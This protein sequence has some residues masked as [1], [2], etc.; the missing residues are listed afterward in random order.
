MKKRTLSILLA[1]SLLISTI[2]V[3]NISVY[4]D[5]VVSYGAWYESMYAEWNGTSGTEYTVSYKES[6]TDN[7]TA[8]DKELVREVNSGQFRVDVLGL[9][10]NV[11]YD[12]KIENNGTSVLEFTD[13]PMAYDRSGFAFDGSNNAPGAYNADGT[14]AD[15]ALIIYASEA[16]KSKVYNNK[17][18][19]SILGGFNSLNGG[20]PV[21]LRIIGKITPVGSATSPGMWKNTCGVTI[22]GVGPGAGFSGWGI[23]SGDNSDTEFR[24]LNFAD[25]VEDAIGFENAKKLWVH[26]NN[27]YSGYNPKDSTAERDKLHGD[28][29]CDLRECNNV[30]VSYNHFDGTDKTSLIGSSST[31][32]EST[33]NIT[34]HHNFF[35]GTSQRTPRV[36]WHNI[37]AYNNYYYNTKAYGIG[38]TCNCSIFAENNYF[39]DAASP[40]LTSSQGGYASKFS[41]NEGGVIK[42]YNNTFVNT[43]ECVEGVDF[44]NAPS[45]EYRMTASDFTTV[46]GGWTYNNFDSTG[47]IASNSY[48]L[49]SPDEAKAKV[50]AEAGTIKESK[51]QNINTMNPP[52]VDGHVSAVYYYDP[53]TTGST[54]NNYGGLNG[55]GTYFSGAGTCTNNSATGYRGTEQ[56]HY[57]GSFS[58]SATISFTTENPAKFTIICSTSGT[59]PLRMEVKNSQNSDAVYHGTFQSGNKGGDVLTTIDLL[60]AGTYSFKANSNVDIYYMEVAEYNGDTPI[61]ESTT[62][63]STTVI[64]TES[65][66]STTVGTT[67]TTTDATTEATTEVITEVT[68]EAATEETTEATTSDLTPIEL[69]EAVTGFESDT[70]GDTGSGVSVTYNSANDTWIL[71]DTSSTAAAS[72]TI[73]FEAIS[74]GKVYI[75]GKAT[76]SAN[77]SKWG[78]AQIRGLKDANATSLSEIVGIGSDSNKNLAVRTYDANGTAVF[79]SLN[80]SLQANKEYNYN[81]VID[82]DSKTA[83]VDVDG[84]KV[85]VDIVADNVSAFYSTTSKKSQRNVT[86]STP[87]VSV[88]KTDVEPEFLYGDADG[89]NIV[90]MIDVV[91]M[92]Q[93]VLTGEKLGLEDKTS[94]YMN[95]VDLDRDGVITSRDCAMVLQKLMDNS[96]S[97]FK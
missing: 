69:G 44:F 79:T 64:S 8:V 94:D 88:P 11:S 71:T 74:S 14:V 77:A 3:L 47:Y 53:E 40:F 89:N 33:G 75:S 93:N 24:N 73:P 16:N 86:V 91:D 28:G 90:N 18:L 17:S 83:E 55:S 25:Y 4:A 96:Y 35:D 68:T 56:Y 82:M 45:R 39:E 32:R 92:L 63:E 66:E 97:F 46:K 34:F 7:Y 78:I 65:T 57:D 2:G 29:S 81:I 52:S 67:Q 70:S 22:E 31:S 38:A 48:E 85:N 10:G 5:D 1:L 50:I 62:T 19:T 76:P 49:D 20:K 95:Y 43:R 9:K 36:R 87:N 72:L 84:T 15:G 30:T 23:G 27:F 58:S 60:E 41:D 42:A 12:V 80:S 21:I 54:G 26:N 61:T 37:H 6:G 51:I 59:T 13:T